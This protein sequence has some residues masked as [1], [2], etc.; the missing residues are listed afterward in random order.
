[1]GKK[2]ESVIK[3]LESVIKSNYDDSLIV[4]SSSSQTWSIARMI[5]NQIGGSTKWTQTIDLGTTGEAPND[6]G[7]QNTMHCIRDS[8]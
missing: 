5:P 2:L 3:L 8:I 1:M 6:G 4:G 7:S